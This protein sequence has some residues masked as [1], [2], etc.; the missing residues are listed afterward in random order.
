MKKW[1]SAEKKGIIS[2]PFSPHPGKLFRELSQHYS[3]KIYTK[4]SKN[5]GEYF[6]EMVEKTSLKDR[7]LLTHDRTS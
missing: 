1:M 5:L 4:E 6:L 7:I 2:N 3:K